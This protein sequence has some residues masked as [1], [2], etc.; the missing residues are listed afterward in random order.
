MYDLQSV[1]DFFYL[2]FWL[3]LSGIVAFTGFLVFKR[4]L[5]LVSAALGVLSFMAFLYPFWDYVVG[6]GLADKMCRESAGE[7]KYTDLP[8]MAEG[9]GYQSLGRGIGVED[10]VDYLTNRKYKY[11]EEFYIDSVGSAQHPWKPSLN[12]GEARSYRLVEKDGG[13]CSVFE[14]LTAKNFTNAIHA[15]QHGMKHNQCIEVT[16]NKKP[17]AKYFYKT[18]EFNQRFPIYRK[19]RK[20]GYYDTS[21]Q[22]P[23]VENNTWYYRGMVL[24]GRDRSINCHWENK[25]LMVKNHLKDF[26]H[27][28]GGNNSYPKETIKY[29]LQDVSLNSGSVYL[30][31][32]EPNQYISLTE[33]SKIRREILGFNQ[34]QVRV[35]RMGGGYGGRDSLVFEHEAKEKAVVLPEI[36]HDSFTRSKIHALVMHEGNFIILRGDDMARQWEL[37]TYSVSENTL[38]REYLPVRSIIDRKYVKGASSLSGQNVSTATRANDLFLTDLRVTDQKYVLSGYVVAS[39]SGSSKTKTFGKFSIDVS[40]H[41]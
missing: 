31:D 28:A 21:T 26:F 11:V 23:L 8:L 36:D 15:Y 39:L 10:V 4:G 33:V 30:K 29:S 32:L 1:G 27:G 14:K 34:N 16:V 7:V 13:N 37:M 20:A 9:L 17:R 24:F 18:S 35:W 3:G 19:V 22:K 41:Q 25:D 12:E 40:R 6:I 38:K 2:I 5:T